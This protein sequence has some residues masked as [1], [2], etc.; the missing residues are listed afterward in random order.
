[1]KKIIFTL[2]LCPL[3][4]SAMEQ[5]NLDDIIPEASY[6]VYEGAENDIV[7][8]GSSIPGSSTY[9]TFYNATGDELETITKE[10]CDFFKL[11]NK[12]DSHAP[13]CQPATYAIKYWSAFQLGGG[14]TKGTPGY[15]IV[16]SD[17]NGNSIKS[18]R[19]HTNTHEITIPLPEN[20]NPVINFDTIITLDSLADLENLDLSLV[21]EKDS[22]EIKEHPPEPLGL[23]GW[24][25]RGLYRL[26][27]G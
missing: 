4:T 1:M 26:F 3:F 21:Q 19:C 14:M 5:G 11:Q 6:Y 10:Q 15:F 9:A 22:D 27:L 16:F 13:K 24:I 17:K 8:P 2:L 12:L 25:T 18:Y 7:A 23:T 20:G